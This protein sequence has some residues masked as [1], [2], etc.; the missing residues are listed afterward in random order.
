V[1]ASREVI[2]Y[3]YNEEEEAI[4]M[5]QRKLDRRVTLKVAEKYHQEQ[6]NIVAT[7]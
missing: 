2:S 7:S 4:R 3:L 6:F 5:L 1:R